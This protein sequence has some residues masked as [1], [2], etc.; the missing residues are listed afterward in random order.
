[1][2]NPISMR[3]PF[4]AQIAKLPPEIQTVHRTSWNAITDLQAAIPVLKSQIDA[5]QASTSTLSASTSSNVTATQANSIAATAAFRAIA[6]SFNKTNNQTGTSYVVQNGDSQGVVTLNNSSAVSVVLGGDGT[7]VGPQFGAYV[8]NVGNGTV[9]VTP[10]TGTVNRSSNLT[11]AQNQSVYVVFDGANWV[12]TTS[13]PGTITGVLASTGLSGG[14]ASGA[15][16]LAIAN[17]A[18]T[19]GTY[20]LPTIAVDAQGRVTAASNGPTGASGTISLAELTP[21]GTR[22]SVTFVDGIITSFVQPS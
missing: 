14:G 13:L 12:A 8:Q 21:T 22:G 11:L 19:P 6:T 16:A 20:V 15:V 2:T 7:G 3:F 17:T 10:A 4:E 5:L 1:M 18:V 9:T